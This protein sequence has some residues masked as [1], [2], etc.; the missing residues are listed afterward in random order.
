MAAGRRAA[1]SERG[2]RAGRRRRGRGRR[3]RGRTKEDEGV[4]GG[5]WEE[6]GCGKGD[7]G[8]LRNATMMAV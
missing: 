2:G 7:G 3:G 1:D 6:E 5:R 8:L 4:E